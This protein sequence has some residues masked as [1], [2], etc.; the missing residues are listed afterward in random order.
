MTR[1]SEPELRHVSGGAEIHREN[2]VEPPPGSYRPYEDYSD[3]KF[4]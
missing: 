4:P 2:P 1:L 3:I